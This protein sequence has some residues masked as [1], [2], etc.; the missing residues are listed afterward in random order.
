MKRTPDKQ[1]T[2]NYITALT[3]D[4]TASWPWS[5]SATLANTAVTPASYTNAN[6]TVDSK[7]R[8]TSA[9]NG[10]AGFGTVTSV[11]ISG[12]DW[13]EV[14]SGSPITTS[15]TIALWVNKTALLAHINV[16]DEP[17]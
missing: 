2:G 8:I 7:G 16:E 17:M 12:F 14:D 5:A 6:I 1:P 4:V 9:S 13:L 11:A 3:G 10:S 15:G